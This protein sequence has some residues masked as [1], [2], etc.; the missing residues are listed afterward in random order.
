MTKFKY[1]LA[2]VGMFCLFACESE[3][4]TTTTVVP[5]TKPVVE[6]PQVDYMYTAV[7]YLR[8][9]DV[10]GMD[11][12]VVHMLA[13]NQRVIDL[14]EKSS[15]MT[16]VTMRGSEMLQPWVKVMTEDSIV[17]WVYRG[18]M[19]P[20]PLSDKDP[21][22]QILENK[23]DTL[24]NKDI[25]QEA[26]IYK[27]GY[28][29]A[30]NIDQLA[31]VFRES[32]GLRDTMNALLEIKS[33]RY[34]D[35]HASVEGLG[36]LE[37]AMPGYSLSVAAEGTIFYLFQDYREWL[38]KAKKVDGTVD[39]DFF[40]L[41]VAINPLDSVEHFFPV[42]FLQTWDYGGYSE[43]G[44]G[45]H[46]EMLDKMDAQL[47]TSKEFEKE[48]NE[49]KDALIWDIVNQHSPYWQSKE[50]IIEEIDAI[51]ESNFKILTKNDKI[52]LKTRR[53]QFEDPAA[54]GIEVNA[55]AGH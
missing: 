24:F 21:A 37:E 17:G 9:R 50:K 35:P 31:Y 26:M 39:D 41:C 22:L 11:G 38:N 40:N 1:L 45:I 2:L 14:K 8:M 28:E 49:Y 3:P 18:G 15:F 47:T 32:N 30:D 34:Q 23:L 43:L 44:K 36:W 52:A 5:P 48:I 33:N 20:K 27:K 54:N 4:E 10:A 42:W 46:K 16:K 29:M 7:N 12:K 25:R 6:A 13:E 51:I 55:R 53:K 19:S